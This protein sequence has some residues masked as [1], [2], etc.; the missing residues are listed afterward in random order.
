MIELSHDVVARYANRRNLPAA[1]AE[2]LD[3]LEFRGEFPF[4]S[5]A[6]LH[7][8][9]ET[10]RMII[11][12]GEVEPVPDRE[13]ITYVGPEATPGDMLEEKPTATVSA[14]AST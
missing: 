1:E 11:A 14:V 12:P 7:A 4:S 3:N 2:M 9:Y 6:E 8:F 10:L 5:E 13:P